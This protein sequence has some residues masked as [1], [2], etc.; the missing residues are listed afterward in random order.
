MKLFVSVLAITFAA[1]CNKPTLEQVYASPV[2]DRASGRYDYQHSIVSPD[3][4]ATIQLKIAVWPFDY[5]KESLENA[6]I[7]NGDW[8]LSIFLDRNS[9]NEAAIA[10]SAVMEAITS[11]VQLRHLTLIARSQIEP[12]LSENIDEVKS[13]QS[14]NDALRLGNIFKVDLIVIGS[15][16]SGERD[17]EFSI[18]M[19]LMDVKKK[20]AIIKSLSDVCTRC[21]VAKLQATSKSMAT[22]LLLVG[23]DIESIIYLLPGTRY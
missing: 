7:K 22:K 13:I 20:G 10:T 15:V 14:V 21:D 18:S 11:N 23:K 3:A 8:L 9:E 16:I 6:T 4:E 1:A 19:Q 12:L 17:G 2:G 5:K